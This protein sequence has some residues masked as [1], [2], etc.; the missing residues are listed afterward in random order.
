VNYVDPWGL[1][2][3]KDERNTPTGIGGVNPPK[4]WPWA[5]G[6]ARVWMGMEKSSRRFK[7]EQNIENGT[8]LMVHHI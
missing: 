6:W 5:W 4:G 1:E 8:I 7:R 2:A 3:Q